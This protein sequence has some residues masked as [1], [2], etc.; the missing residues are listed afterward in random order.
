MKNG[1]FL[2][3][4][5]VMGG[6]KASNG[7]LDGFKKRNNITFKTSVG[8]AGLV[9]SKIIQN[10]LNV[11]LPDLIKD[12][13]PRNIFNADETGL[14][15]KAMPNKTMYYKNL[16]CNKV[17][18]VKD[19]LSILFC[20]NM[21]GS[22][23]LKPLVIGK[24]ENPRCFSGI[25]RVNLPVNYT[26]NRTAWMNAE[27]FSKFLND[28]DN[29]MKRT[30]RTI[31][32]FLDNFSGHESD[33]VLGNVKIH[34]F[35]PNCTSVLQP[36]DQG[37]IQAFKMK[38]RRLLIE[39]KL[40]SLK[41]ESLIPDIDVLYAVNKIGES[42]KS[43][44]LLTIKNCFKHSGLYKSRE[45]NK[46]NDE[47]VQVNGDEDDMIKEKRLLDQLKDK[48]NFDIYKYISID[49]KLSCYGD[50][51]DEEIVTSIKDSEIDN[52][53]TIDQSSENSNNSSNSN[54]VEVKISPALAL[55]HLDTVIYYL[56]QESMDMNVY[57]EWLDKIYNHIATAR[58][59]N[60]VKIDDFL[61]KKDN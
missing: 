52:L 20:S 47:H 17:K 13:E 8:E 53:S 37:I 58:R 1:V 14:F 23:K 48:F 4:R 26:N 16:A 39:D 2:N 50:M 30:N 60:Q 29:R 3:T 15:Y 12:Y 36:M 5:Q 10:Y 28:L 43:I 46:E 49:D 33:L 7:W 34:F 54:H 25:N 57:L 6:F 35:P 18:V 19:R 27:I 38:Y 55:S 42:W 32:L 51:T 9:D 40:L 22:E 59:F 44:S 61:T 11:V 41:T 31:L 45:S 24:S 56:Q 21:D